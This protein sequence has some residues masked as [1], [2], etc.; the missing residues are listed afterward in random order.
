MQALLNHPFFGPIARVCS[1]AGIGLLPQRLR[2]EFGFRWCERDE[3]RLSTLTA[4]SRRLRR[5]LPGVVC[6]FPA[7][8]YYAWR[9]GH[10]A[11]A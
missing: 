2:A 4:W 6:T 8:S 1:Y 7:A 9:Y 3:R 5:Y 11:R 10:D